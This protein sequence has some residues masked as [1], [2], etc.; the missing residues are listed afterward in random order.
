MSDFVF[1]FQVFLKVLDF[2]G[3]QCIHLHLFFYYSFEFIDIRI[4]IVIHKADTLNFGYEL[5]FL[6]QQFRVLLDR[7][8]MGSKDFFLLFKDITNLLLESKELFVF[9]ISH[10][11]LHSIEIISHFFLLFHFGLFL[12]LNFLIDGI[13]FN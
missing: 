12:N 11:S 6:S 10:G 1:F 8:H 9:L 5:T 7:S 2:F 4:H 3:E 13:F